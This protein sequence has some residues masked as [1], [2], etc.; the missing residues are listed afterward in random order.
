MLFFFVCFF[1]KRHIHGTCQTQ[2]VGVSRVHKVK[3]AEASYKFEFCILLVVKSTNEE[4]YPG[5]YN[6]MPV[7]VYLTGQWS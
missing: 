7:I 6:A 3:I 5:F 4:L 2:Y 1:L